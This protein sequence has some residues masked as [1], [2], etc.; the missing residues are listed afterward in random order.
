MS[1]SRAIRRLC[2]TSVSSP[3][4]LS[5]LNELSPEILAQIRRDE[6]SQQPTQVVSGSLYD[7]QG[8]IKSLNQCEL[9]KWKI[10]QIAENN[11]QPSFPHLQRLRTKEKTQ[12]HYPFEPVVGVLRS[13][14]RLSSLARTDVNWINKIEGLLAEKTEDLDEARSFHIFPLTSEEIQEYHEVRQNNL[15]YNGTP[16][17]GRYERFMQTTAWHML[18]VWLWRDALHHFLSRSDLETDPRWTERLIAKVSNP[19]VWLSMVNARKLESQIFTLS[20]QKVKDWII[21]NEVPLMSAENELQE[22]QSRMACFLEGLDD[23]CKDHF[24]QRIPSFD[25]KDVMFGLI[26]LF[27]RVR[28]YEENRCGEPFNEEEASLRLTRYFFHQ[29]HHLKQFSFEELESGDWW[30]STNYDLE[31]PSEAETS[32]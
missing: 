27:F 2:Q 31:E 15:H 21:F 20:W 25:G 6:L 29:R 18:H 3:V 8:L 16:Q 28:I 13:M 17:P 26:H 5:A 32:L 22:A 1:I 10:L 12:A 4:H 14:A 23:I 30:W 19:R 9:I 11:P 24:Q 7:N